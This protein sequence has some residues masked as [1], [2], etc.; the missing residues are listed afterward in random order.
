VVQERGC[1]W[2]ILGIPVAGHRTSLCRECDQHIRPDGFDLR[3]TT[4][5]GP[6]GERP[7]DRFRERIVA[8]SVENDQL[9]ALCRFQRSENAIKLNGLVLK[10]EIA[11]QFGVCRFR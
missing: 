9:E 4:A 8:A 1:E 7:L 11:E 5:Y 2:T 3:Q 6:A 10:V